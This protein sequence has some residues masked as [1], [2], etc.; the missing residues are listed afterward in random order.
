MSPGELSLT[1]ICKEAMG[2]F[3]GRMRIQG[4]GEWGLCRVREV[5]SYKK[6]E[7]MVGPCEEFVN[8]CL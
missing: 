6:W 4:G 8:W 3:K 7:G 5:K 1:W 2:D